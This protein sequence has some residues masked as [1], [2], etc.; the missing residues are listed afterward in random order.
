MNFKDYFNELKLVIKEH[1]ILILGFIFVSIILQFI[2]IPFISV[3][4]MLILIFY[5][6]KTEQ[7]KSGSLIGKIFQ[8]ILFFVF[9]IIFSVIILIPVSVISLGLENLTPENVAD[10][11]VIQN[12]VKIIAYISIL[13]IFAPYRILDTNANV[14]KAIIYSCSV[15]INNFLIFIITT[16]FVVGLNI[17]TIN[18]SMFDYYVY[19][20]T[21]ILTASIYR[22]HVKQT[23][24]KGDKNENN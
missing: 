23:L 10:S 8:F 19:L 14:F 16:I 20:L 12:A 2:S 18:I 15:V 22:L 4:L 5:L 21:I 1:Y 7:Y 6:S 3:L 17:L 13:F 11:Y 24:I 9:I